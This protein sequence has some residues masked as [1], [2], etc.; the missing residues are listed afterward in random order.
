MIKTKLH[1]FHYILKLNLRRFKTEKNSYNLTKEN[2][3]LKMLVSQGTVYKQLKAFRHLL[4]TSS[5]LNGSEVV[6][7]THYATVL[8][9]S[10]PYSVLLHYLFSYAPADFKSPHQ[11]LDWPIAKYSEW[12]EAHTGERERL[13]VVKTCL[14]AYVNMVTHKNEKQFAAIYPLMFRL[15]EKS[16]EALI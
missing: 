9:E 2:R 10:L 1:I 16:L 13:L 14:E 12:I 6:D 8:S 15:L 7:E 5:P 11:S 3:L 4:Q